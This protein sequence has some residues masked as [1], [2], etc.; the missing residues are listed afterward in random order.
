[1]PISNRPFSFRGL[2]NNDFP[3]FPDHFRQLKNFFQVGLKQKKVDRS[4]IF[5]FF[6]LLISN[7]V[8]KVPFFYI[9]T[10]SPFYE[11]VKKFLHSSKLLRQKSTQIKEHPS[12]EASTN[13]NKNFFDP[14]TFLP[15]STLVYIR[16]DLSTI[17]QTRLAIHLHR[18]IRLDLC[19]VFSTLAYIHLVTR[20]HS[21][22]FVQICLDLSSL[23]FQDR[24]YNET[25][26]T[27]GLIKSVQKNSNYCCRIKT[28]AWFPRRR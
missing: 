3:S 27:E 15:S 10:K 23:C 24:T 16:L 5:V 13:F 8:P 17:V 22:T 20:L 11:N 18:Q 7:L 21:P 12:W 14:F 19:S 4:D 25:N 26:T 9:R 6:L 28:K 2:L 1:M